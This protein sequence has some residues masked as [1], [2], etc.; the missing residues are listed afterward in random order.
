MNKYVN[1]ADAC[2]GATRLII[3]AKET[4]YGGSSRSPD[5]KSQSFDQPSNQENLGASSFASDEIKSAYFRAVHRASDFS[6]IH[7]S[8]LAGSSE[9]SFGRNALGTGQQFSR[10]SIRSG[11]TRTRGVDEA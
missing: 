1:S 9:R 8:D 6:A 4:R 5:P 11:A 3:I 2:L 7:R 10:E